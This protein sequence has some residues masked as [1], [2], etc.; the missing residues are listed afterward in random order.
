MLAY[1]CKHIFTFLVRN[2]HVFYYLLAGASQE[3]KDGYG[4]TKPEDYFYLNQVTPQP[5]LSSN[6]RSTCSLL[7]SAISSN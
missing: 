5:H 6:K 4:L 1:D 2:Y 3:D 7:N